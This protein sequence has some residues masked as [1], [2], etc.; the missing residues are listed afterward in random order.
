[1]SASQP[2][3][4][5]PASAFPFVEGV[6]FPPVKFREAWPGQRPPKANTPNRLPMVSLGAGTQ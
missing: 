6:T 1:M 2:L 5:S 3:A 4:L